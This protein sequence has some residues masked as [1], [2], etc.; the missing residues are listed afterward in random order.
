MR[1]R[2]NNGSWLPIIGQNNNDPETSMD[3]TARRVDLV[4]NNQQVTVFVSS[5]IY[6]VPLEPDSE[7]IGLTN[8]GAFQNNEYFLK[9]VVGKINVGM[10]TEGSVAM[11]TIDTNAPQKF[12][13]A[14]G[15]FVA[16]AADAQLA[17][18]PVGYPANA[19]ADYNPL[20]PNCIREPWLWRRTW[21]L[22]SP[23]WNYLRE[24]G[25]VS[26]GTTAPNVIP[27]QPESN[28][29]FG[30]ALDGPHVDARTRRRVSSDDRLW[31]AVAGH[32]LPFGGTAQGTG[33]ANFDWEFRVFGS[34]RRARNSGTF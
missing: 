30:S 7:Q 10:Q 3:T 9:R 4:L 22:G 26:G 23:Y 24:Q 29:E 14:A 16:R 32:A 20:D 17:G 33:S 27:R 31:L 25:I 1:K 15:L 28:A 5:V 18:F 6:D 2:R 8:L 11:P 21:V 12:I 13:V 34:M 19:Q